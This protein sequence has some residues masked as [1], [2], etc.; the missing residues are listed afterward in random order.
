MADD[1]DNIDDTDNSNGIENVDYINNIN[2]IIFIFDNSHIVCCFIQLNN[3]SQRKYSG[4]VA[5]P[6]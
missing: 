2:Y 3:S 4:T 1:I 6:D 5:K